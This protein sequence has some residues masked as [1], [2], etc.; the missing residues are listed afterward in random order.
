MNASS[1]QPDSTTELTVRAARGGRGPATWGQRAVHAALV[2]LGPDAP[3]YN[4]RTAAPVEP[5]LPPETALR[6]FAE[7]L[8]LHDAL[9]T[10]LVEE[11]GDLVQDVDAGGV[12]PVAVLRRASA[13]LAA[14]A[15]AE[16]LARFAARPFDLPGEWPVRLGLVL[17]DGLVR[18]VVLVLSHTASDGWGMRRAVRDLTL[19]AAGRSADDLRAERAFA[20]PL[21]EAAEQD[22]PRGRRRDAA[23]RRHWRDRLG[24]GPRVQLPRPDGEPDPARRFPLAVLRSPELA[25]ALP[26]AAAR[27]RTG[28]ATVLLAAAA[29]ELGRLGGQRELLFQV[30]VGNR[31]TG[32]AA[33][34]VTTLAQEG[35]FHLPELAEE[36]AET[37]RRCQGPAL[38]AYRHSGYHKPRLD[39]ELAALRA[40]GAEL[41]DHSVIWNDT[42]DPLAASM[43][44]GIGE[45]PPVERELSFPDTFPARP[46]AS[47]AV[48]VVA[49]PG[50]IELLM[51]ADGALLDRA[52]MARFLCG[53][54]QLVLDAAGA[55]QASVDA[56]GRRESVDSRRP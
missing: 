14:G 26:V 46:G 6:A 43:P 2:A 45:A 41:A 42:R 34:A 25:A 16:L 21:E 48:D 12:L 4:L 56:D 38:A 36:F 35:L 54:E 44:D 33:E 29:T 17:V 30:V 10:R 8:H 7:L 24:S 1:E 55:G 15:A 40:G 5:G 32:Q 19:L 20:Q 52:R 23:A 11:D 37:V 49:V 13:E 3:R 18:Q 51:V 22:S 39:A 28:D 47:V 50:A 9:R 31:F 27:L 53:V